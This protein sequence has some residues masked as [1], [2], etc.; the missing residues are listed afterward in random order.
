MYV[1]RF[2]YLYGLLALVGAAGIAAVL[3]GPVAFGAPVRIQ[4]EYRDA[5]APSTIKQARAQYGT[6]TQTVDGTQL[7]FPAGV[8]CDVYELSDGISLLCYQG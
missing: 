8:K 1:E 3:L 7:G 4:T 6:A 2:R 5:P